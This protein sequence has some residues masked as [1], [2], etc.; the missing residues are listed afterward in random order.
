MSQCINR[1]WGESTFSTKVL[2]KLDFVLRNECEHNEKVIRKRVRKKE[3]QDSVE[4]AVLIIV[5]AWKR[6]IRSNHF[7]SEEKVTLQA[8]NVLN[9]T[10]GSLRIHASG[11]QPESINPST[12]RVCLENDYIATSVEEVNKFFS[13]VMKKLPKGTTWKSEFF[14]AYYEGSY[15]SYSFY[16]YSFS[17]TIDMT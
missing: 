15:D 8:N 5:N 3:F 16:S 13:E 4:E 2:E 7:Y 11:L 17:I 12:G 10:K 1:D 14:H 9:A 6:D